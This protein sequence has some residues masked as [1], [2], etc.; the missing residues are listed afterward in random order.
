[1]PEL[2]LTVPKSWSDLRQTQLRDVYRAMVTTRQWYQVATICITKWNRLKMIT[3][4]ANGYLFKLNKRGAP[5]ME[6]YL[7]LSLLTNIAYTMEWVREPS[8]VPVRL[9]HID[10]AK[11]IPPD[12]SEDLSFEE[13][14]AC[15][16]LWHGYQATMD[17]KL[18]REMAAILYHKPD[19]SLAPHESMSIFY[20]WVSAKQ[21]ISSNFPHFFRPAGP[22]A[23]DNGRQLIDGMNA[24][25]RALTK[26][27]IT[28]EAQILAMNAMRALTELDALAR[29]Y[30]ELNRKYPQKNNR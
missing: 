18:L 21:L 15:E 16:N 28:K 1:M 27:D 7:S 3:P 2:N 24:Q 25:I 5:E 17:N 12:L 8:P 13:W 26:G 22:K 6:I 29:E 10:G 11:A 19:I 20:W 30:E 9:T 4:Y 14:L 23:M